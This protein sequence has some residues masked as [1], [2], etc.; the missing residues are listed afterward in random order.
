MNSIIQ[1]IIGCPRN[2]ILNED[3]EGRAG[4]R[5]MAVWLHTQ[6]VSGRCFAVK[7]VSRTTGKH[8]IH[9]LLDIGGGIENFRKKIKEKFPFLKRGTYAICP[10]KGKPIY[11]KDAIAKLVRYLC[12]GA[13]SG[14]LPEIWIREKFEFDVQKEHEEYWRENMRLRNQEAQIVPMPVKKVQKPGIVEM[15]AN[16][17]ADNE[18]CLTLTVD[19]RRIVFNAV[20]RKLGHL[21]RILDPMIVRRLCY[22]VHNLLN[23]EELRDDIWSQVYPE[24]F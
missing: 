5:T 4:L 3:T 18:N 22:G 10:E 12:K 6:S 19:C 9:V 16:E 17:L 1:V 8:H 21:K 23:H 11:D 24:Y 13:S 15:V 20:M 7:E 2:S 14:T